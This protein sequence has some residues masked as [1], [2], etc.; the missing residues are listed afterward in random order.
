MGAQ[1]S[2]DAIWSFMAIHGPQIHRKKMLMAMTRF[3][4][5]KHLI[6]RRQVRM[7]HVHDMT[8]N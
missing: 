2:F 3:K 7:V 1:D 6:I 5:N 4:Y 8:A